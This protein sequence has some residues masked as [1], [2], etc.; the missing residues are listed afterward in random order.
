MSVAVAGAT[1][2][3]GKAVV[4]RL[5]REGVPTR[6]LVRDQYE[7]VRPRLKCYICPTSKRSMRRTVEP[8][9]LGA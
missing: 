1:G 9:I 2:G 6:A 4:E 8:F 5:A 3:V 7:A